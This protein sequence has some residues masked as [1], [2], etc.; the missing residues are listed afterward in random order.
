LL[1]DAE[2]FLE[3]RYG[4]IIARALRVDDPGWCSSEFAEGRLTVRIKTER[5]ESLISACEDYFRTVKAALD[6]LEALEI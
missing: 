3:C 2:L 5:I 1:C 6:A 4:D